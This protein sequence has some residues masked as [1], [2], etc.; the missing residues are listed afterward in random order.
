MGGPAT[1]SLIRPAEPSC[2]CLKTNRIETLDRRRL[3]GTC[4]HLFALTL[5]PVGIKTKVQN[6]TRRRKCSGR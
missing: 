1:I 3:L 6:F 4:S 5:V 2:G